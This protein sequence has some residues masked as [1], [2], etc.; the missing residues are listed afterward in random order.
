M[1]DQSSETS[2]KEMSPDYDRVDPLASHETNR[3]GEVSE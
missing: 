1:D 2:N 3:I